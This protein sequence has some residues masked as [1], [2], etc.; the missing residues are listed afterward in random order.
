MPEDS[1]SKPP[2]P[3]DDDPVARLLHRTRTMRGLPLVIDD[4]VALERVAEILASAEDR[5]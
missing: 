5:K 2:A 3:H 4:P 1:H